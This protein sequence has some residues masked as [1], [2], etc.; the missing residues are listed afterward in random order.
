M[1]TK[2]FKRRHKLKYITVEINV[3]H[4]IQTMTM[5]II[6]TITVTDNDDHAKINRKAKKTKCSLQVSSGVPL[7]QIQ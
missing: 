5:A 3:K 1:T 7:N 2:S 4:V 6:A